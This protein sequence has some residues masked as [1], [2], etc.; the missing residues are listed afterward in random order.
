MAVDLFSL[1]MKIET[2]GAAQA[3]AELKGLEAQGPRTA[4]ALNQGTIA[5]DR[6]AAAA[7][8]GTKGFKDLSGAYAK[9]DAVMAGL[10]AKTARATEALTKKTAQVGL[11]GLA[12]KSMAAW[13]AGFSLLSFTKHVIESA[14]AL[15]ELSQRTG[16]SVRL[17]SILNFAGQQAGVG[18]AEIAQG[19]RGL[20]MS[21]GQLRDGTPKAVEAFARIGLHAQDLKGLNVDQVFQKVVEK[22]ALLPDG[23]EKAEAAQRIF[24]RGGAVLLPLLD[25]LATKGFAKVTEEAEKMGAV[26]DAKAA[27]RA[28]AFGDALT[29]LKGSLG[30]LIREAIMPSLGPLST[31]IDFLALAAQKASTMPNWLKVFSVPGGL[32]MAAWEKMFG[33]PEAD[34]D[35]GG[36]GITA[37]DPAAAGRL[38]SRSRNR[39]GP[40]IDLGNK[41]P[42]DAD[43]KAAAREA[44]AK[45]KLFNEEVLRLAN[46]DEAMKPA[47]R[48]GFQGFP[49]RIAPRTG[50]IGLGDFGAGMGVPGGD[51]AFDELEE[52]KEQARKRLGRS[53]R[54]FGSDLGTTVVQGFA[55]A[56]S[57]GLQGK[58]PFK[59]FGNVVL[60]G[61]G[62]LMTQMGSALIS[63]GITML[64]LL[65]FLT[66][67]FTSGPAAIAAGAA[68]VALG[69]TLGGIAT[70]SKGGGGSKGGLTDKT[71]HITLTADGLGGHNAPKGKGAF[72]GATL[73]SVDSPKGQRALTTSIKGAKRRNMG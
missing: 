22:L 29:R 37:T 23:F 11:I 66:N 34:W 39:F 20:S 49:S 13:Y 42:S 28:D 27:A 64:N 73:L 51:P 61:L 8:N 24:G 2:T 68:L 26:I 7:I 56:M 33:S 16:A 71:T 46:M 1:R 30:A 18:T 41:A 10:P 6:N 3:S 47:G 60:S 72:D 5:M 32:G 14:G 53:F 36:G 65:P 63:Y 59:A 40:G 31:F 35:P 17:L 45:R 50:R 62:S 48:L 25:D 21:L 4:A 58:N 38:S 57:A 55:A 43:V 15:H 70:G 9:H 69:S 12:L 67:I 54:E 52:V 44:A 19:F